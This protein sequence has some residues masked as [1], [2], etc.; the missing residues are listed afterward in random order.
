MKLK[1]FIEKLLQIQ[2]EQGKDPEVVMA[3][4]ISV[5][6]PIFSNQY[7]GKKVIITDQKTNLIY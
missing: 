6:E 3:D 5:V 4:N 7:H 2:K 1:K